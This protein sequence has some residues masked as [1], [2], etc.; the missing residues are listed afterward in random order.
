MSLR[1]DQISSELTV[2]NSTPLFIELQGGI[3]SHL[4]V[5][6]PEAAYAVGLQGSNYCRKQATATEFSIVPPTNSEKNGSSSAFLRSLVQKGFD[7]LFSGWGIRK[8]QNEEEVK[9]EEEKEE[10]EKEEYDDYIQMNDKLSRVYTSTPVQFT[11]IDRV[12]I[13][14]WLIC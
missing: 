6:T 5:S 2:T 12:M 3:L 9:V 13:F 4:T 8:H 7:G 10:E 14:T 11:V 1:E